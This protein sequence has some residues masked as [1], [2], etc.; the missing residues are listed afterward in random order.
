MNVN[1]RWIHSKQK[2]LKHLYLSFSTYSTS[3][4]S[5]ILHIDAYTMIEWDMTLSQQQDDGKLHS[6]C[7]EN[8]IWSDAECKYDALKLK[9]RELLKALKKFRFWLFRKYF[10]VQ[11][12]SQALVW[13][14]NQSSNDLSNAMITH[15]LI[16]IYFFD[17]DVWYISDNKNDAADNLSRRGKA[18][19]DESDDDS[20]D[21]FESQLYFISTKS[22]TLF[23]SFTRVY[24]CD[25]EYINDDLILRCY[26]ETLEWFER[27]NDEKYQKLRKK[28][29]NFL[30]RDEHLFKHNRKWEISP[31]WMIDLKKQRL[32]IIHEL[33]DETRHRGRKII[34][35]QVQHHYQ[36]KEFYENMIEYVKICEECQWH[37]RNRY[38][39]SMKSIWTIM[40]WVKI[41][42]DVVY[43]PLILKEFGFIVFARD[44]L[45]EWMEEWSIDAI[46][47]QNMARFIYENVIYRHECSLWIIMNDNIENLNLTR[48]LLKHYRIQQMIIFSYHP[49]SNE[50]MK[51]E[52]ESIINSLAK[53]NKKLNDWIKH[54][55]LILWVDRIFV[56]YSINYST[57][58]LI[59]ERKCLLLMELSM[60]S[61]SLIDWDGIK[62]REDLILA[63]M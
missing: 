5:I 17:F 13:L 12:N 33:H 2:L 38:E 9:C 48:N 10:S 56:W 4:F 59:Y 15:W 39:E 26:L 28:S 54:L 14:L 45:S 34:F 36:W 63:R 29:R 11:T 61:W 6:A 51:Y 44:D 58:E 24:L 3:A 16:Y 42:V 41:E 37:S 18:L 19:E 52:H 27:F 35:D 20:D 43:M 62:D 22:L 55:T 21:Y 31:R 32:A 7:Y 25:E 46:N 47:S 57:F 8:D 40:I 53:Y 23:S 1:W 60:T 49:Q 50:L 30:I